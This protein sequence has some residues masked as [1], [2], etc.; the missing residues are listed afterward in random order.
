MLPITRPAEATHLKML[1]YSPAGH[2]KTTFVASAQ[3]DPRSRPTLILDFEGGVSSIADQEIDVIR[4]RSVNDFEET[5]QFLSGGQHDYRTVIIDSLSE[6]HQ[7]FFLTQLESAAREDSR[8][9][10]DVAQQADYSRISIRM[11]RLI[12][13]YRDLPMH[14]LMTA[15][16]RNLEDQITRS[17]TTIPQMIG[18]FANELPGLFDIVAY[19]ALV[20][21]DGVTSRVLVCQPT[22]RFVAKVRVPRSIDFPATTIEP[23]L[24]KVLD[25]LKIPQVQGTS[26]KEQE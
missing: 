20:E 13:F 2:G 5:Y 24:T 19:L 25:L 1:V 22:E 10:P 16:S 9:H 18:S 8:R 21:E 6:I 14:V 12:R 15:G 17:T 26:G 11:R 3:E 7:L 23:T 4:V